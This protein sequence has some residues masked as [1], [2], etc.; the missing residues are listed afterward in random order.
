[1]KSHLVRWHNELS[2]KGL[3][4]INVDNGEIDSLEKVRADAEKS[5]L[6]YP[7]LWDKGGRTIA[8][9]GCTA[10][11]SGVLIGVDGTVLWQGFPP[12]DLPGIERLFQQELAKVKKKD[13]ERWRKEE[14]AEEL[15]EKLRGIQV[16][17]SFRNEPLKNVVEFL[18]ETTGAAIAIDPGAKEKQDSPVTVEWEGKDAYGAIEE[19]VRQADL[20]FYFD[21]DKIV[22][23]TKE[24]VKKKSK[25]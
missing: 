19:L 6:P 4:V 10:F 3:V 22:I 21:G 15:A 24:Q 20:G 5:K 2:P 17:A 9:F 23:A 13:L 1:M 8:A 14:K 16:K 11:A 12:S 18:K 25:K 7:I